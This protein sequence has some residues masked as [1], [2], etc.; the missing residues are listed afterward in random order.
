M[1]LFAHLA[2][3]SLIL[4]RRFHKQVKSPLRP[5]TLKSVLFQAPV[6]QVPVLLIGSDVRCGIHTAHDHP[7]HQGRRVYA[8]QNP[9]GNGGRRRHRLPVRHGFGDGQIA[10][11]FPRQRQRLTVRVYHYRILIE[12]GNKRNL[13]PVIHQL[14]VR[15]IGNQH[16]GMA[17]LPALSLQDLSHTADGL[18]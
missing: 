8:A 14:P 15:L 1:M 18:L 17:G 3:L 7:L 9:M 16:N 11:P 10:D 12:L 5:D 2:E 4:Q 13:Y 6:Q